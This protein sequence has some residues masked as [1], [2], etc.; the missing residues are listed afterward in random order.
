MHSRQKGLLL[1]L[2]MVMRSSRWETCDG[3]LDH[4]R[5][6]MSAVADHDSQPS[7]VVRAIEQG[8]ELVHI[9]QIVVHT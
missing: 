9:H 1:R 4:C 3:S 6:G 5:K 8:T 2:D 7:K